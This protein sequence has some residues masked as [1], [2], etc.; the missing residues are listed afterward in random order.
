MAQLA[1]HCAEA[2]T[3]R[4]AARIRL[5]N[6]SPSMTQTMTPQDK[7]KKW[8]K[9]WAAIRATHPWPAGSPP[10]AEPAE[11]A[12]ASSARAAAMPTEPTMASGLRPTRSTK[13]IAI[14]VPTMLM[15]DV[16]NE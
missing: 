12:H 3:P 6:I 10:S 5:G 4:A 13:T 14:I 9:A 16:V 8:T 15:I 1:I 2:A 7:A 11:N